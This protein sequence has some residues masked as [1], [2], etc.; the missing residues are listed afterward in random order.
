MLFSQ[1]DHLEPGVAMRKLWDIRDKHNRETLGWLGGG[2]VAVI[3]G[4]WAA[5]VYFFP[6]KNDGA[7]KVEASCGSAAA[8]GTFIGSSITTG[9]ASSTANCPTK[10]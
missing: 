5:F 8:Q 3:A 6:P 7:S 9:G 4:L 1:A 10:K 2:L